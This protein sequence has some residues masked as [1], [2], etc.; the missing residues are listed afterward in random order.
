MSTVERFITTTDNP[1][2]YFTQ[3]DEWNAY[4]QR[5]GYHTLA[6]LARLCSTSIELD[7]EENEIEIDEAIDEMLELNITGNYVE[8]RY[9]M[10]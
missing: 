2:D 6:Y 10:K 8:T 9:D 4:D 7:D 3:F 1:F 5:A